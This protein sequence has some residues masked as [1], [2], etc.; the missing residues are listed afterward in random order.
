[1]V[2][3]SHC[4]DVLNPSPLCECFKNEIGRREWRRTLGQN[5]HF[6]FLKSLMYSLPLPNLS[7]LEEIKCGVRRGKTPLQIPSTPP[8]PAPAPAPAP[9]PPLK[10]IQVRFIKPYPSHSL[11]SSLL[12]L[13][14]NKLFKSSFFYI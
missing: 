9:S 14:S 2:T 6:N 11:N 5:W 13:H 8:H 7:N 10:N 3:L 12:S 4:L 1:M